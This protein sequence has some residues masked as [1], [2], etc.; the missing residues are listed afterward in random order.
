MLRPLL[1][2]S[3]PA[4]ELAAYRCI[5]GVQI[6]AFGP[7]ERS[8]LSRCAVVWSP[9]SDGR[10]VCGGRLDYPARSGTIEDAANQVQ[11]GP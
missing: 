8:P 4:R 6:K 3:V 11:I 10:A 5:A 9:L 7:P 1:S 2:R